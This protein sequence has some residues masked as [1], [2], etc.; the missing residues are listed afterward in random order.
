MSVWNQSFAA[1]GFGDS[2]D[3]LRESVCPKLSP[4]HS[5][6]ISDSSLG[7]SSIPLNSCE[8]VSSK[9]RRTQLLPATP[10]AD[11]KGAQKCRLCSDLLGMQYFRAASEPAWR[12]R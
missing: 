5:S 7:R 6:N 1:C 3:H 10:G 8:A 2:L 4:P 12:R 9:L 11:S